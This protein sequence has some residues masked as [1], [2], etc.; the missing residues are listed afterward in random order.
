MRAWLLTAPVATSFGQA[1]RTEA[2]LDLDQASRVTLRSPDRRWKLYTEPPERENGDARLFIAD[3]GGHKRHLLCDYFR[4]GSVGWTR[5]S[6]AAVFID[7]HSVRDS[8]FRMFEFNGKDMS[9]VD[10]VD[11]RLRRRALS[12]VP[13]DRKIVFYSIRIAR[14]GRAQVFLDVTVTYLRK[15]GETGPTKMIERAYAYDTRTHQV[16]AA[17]FSGSYSPVAKIIR[18]YSRSIS[19][20]FSISSKR[21]ASAA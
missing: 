10:G 6:R 20:P 18:V 15:H 12:L 2:I 9:E 4:S 8:T 21:S 5:D 14:L 3:S 1:M 11:E 16:S 19:S 13:A 7:D 17:E